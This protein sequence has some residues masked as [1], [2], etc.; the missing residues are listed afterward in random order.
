VS[1][2]WDAGKLYLFPITI[3][4]LPARFVSPRGTD[5]HRSCED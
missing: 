4:N 2:W 5:S 1:E 3:W